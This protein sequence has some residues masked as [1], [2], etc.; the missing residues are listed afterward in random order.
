[1][2][3]LS[4]RSFVK[5]STVA[6]G[7]AVLANSPMCRPLGARVASDTMRIGIVGCGARGLGALR[8]CL[9]GAP[10]VKI[11]ALAD[12][13]QQQVDSVKSRLKLHDV[14]MFSGFD[15]F[16]KI[17]SV[18]FDLVILAG[19]PGFRPAHFAAAVAAGRHV[20][21]EKPVAV[22]PTGCRAIIETARLAKAKGLAV[23]AGTHR[24]HDPG[25]VETIKRIHDG[26]LGE[27]VAGECYYNT[28]NQIWFRPKKDWIADFTDF[29][30]QCWN[31]YHWGWLSGD[32]IVEQHIHN[33]DIINWAF[34]GPPAK[35]TGMG[36]RQVRGQQPGDIWDH[37]AVEMEYPNGARVMSLCRQTANTSMRIGERVTGTR[38][39]SDCTRTISGARPFKYEGPT[40]EPHIQEQTN[41][42]ASIRSGQLL[43]EGEQVAISTLTAIGGRIAAYTGREISWRWLVEGSKLDIFPKKA[44][45]GP[46]IFTPIPIPGNVTLV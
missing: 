19:P 36:G 18:D 26:A 30:W 41:L 45:P 46:G 7:A 37:F 39:V 9:T 16:E 2:K 1:M 11:V 5:S 3:P 28:S 13:F 17:Y 6:V 33:I 40:P 10:G 31:W 38:G 42:I 14:A 43:N 23:V 32:H 22:D 21:I 44:G 25:Y 8:D 4:R 35:F 12:L 15:A 24:R 20:F 27:L 34:G 29:E